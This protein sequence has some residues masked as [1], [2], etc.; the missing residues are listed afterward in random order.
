MD[1]PF[2]TANIGGV[3]T[4]MTAFKET[5]E[6]HA[7]YN[8]LT[9]VQKGILLLDAMLT[10]THGNRDENYW[11]GYPTHVDQLQAAVAGMEVVA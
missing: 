6:S 9:M 11:V 8:A 5:M 4:K 2:S 3:A 10:T 1:S 7:E